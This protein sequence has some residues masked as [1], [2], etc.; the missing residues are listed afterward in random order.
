M[1]EPLLDMISRYTGLKNLTL[2]AGSPPDHI[3]GD[4]RIVSVHYGRT[5]TVV[6]LRF[7]EFESDQYREKVLGQFSRFLSATSGK[8]NNFVTRTS[9]LRSVQS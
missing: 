1:I 2:L 8:S 4:Y 6:P 3:G 7:S 5:A 9:C